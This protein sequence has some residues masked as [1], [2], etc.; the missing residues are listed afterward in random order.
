MGRA[1]VARLIRDGWSVLCI[2]VN[3]RPAIFSS[4]GYFSH[5]HW[6][7]IDLRDANLEDATLQ[8]LHG[9]PSWCGLVNLAGKS[10]GGPCDAQSDADWQEAFDINVTA[11]MRLTRAAATTLMPSVGS[12]VNVGSPVGQIGARKLGYAAS[13]AAL[14][15]LTMASARDLGQKQIRVNLLL[16]GPTITDMTC[17]WDDVKR[18]QIASNCFQKRLCEP[19]D[20]AA[21][22]AFLL[23]P[24]SRAMTGSI[25][26]LTG[27]SM[28]GH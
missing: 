19:D 9:L 28:Y 21:V 2:D 5:V 3:T 7:Q 6:L 26:D 17:D 18:A 20:I 12:I 15:G 16:P 25:V 22:I 8:A 24:E 11:A 27:G 14:Q 10:V 1:V 23:G 13:K 4:E